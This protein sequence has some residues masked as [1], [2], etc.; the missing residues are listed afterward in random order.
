MASTPPSAPSQHAGDHDSPPRAAT[1]PHTWQ[2]PTGPVEDPYAWM[3]DR[4]DPETIAYIEA[5]NAYTAAWYAG[6]GELRDAIFGEIRSRIQETDESVPF[7]KGGWWYTSRTVEGSNYPLRCRGRDRAT[8]TSEVLLDENA[9]AAGHEYLELGAFDV[10]PSGDLLLYSVDTD[11][12]EEYELRIRDLRT[13]VDL[14]DTVDRIYYSTAW[15]AD[16]RHVFYCVPNDQMRPH[17]VWRHELGTD[18]TADV[19][20]VQEDDARF[21]LHVDL[22]RDERWISIVAASQITTEVWL[23]PADRPTEAPASVAGRVDGREYG[24][25]PWGDRFVVLTND[26]AEDFRIMTA[27]LDRPGDWTEFVGHVPGRRIDD[28]EAFEHHLLIHEWADGQ[29]AIRVVFRDGT[30]RR[31]D[32]GDEPSD[33]E[34]DANP[35]WTASTVR[36]TYQSLTMPLSV[37]EEDVVTGERTLL[38]RQPV[39]NVD[40]TQYESCR[41]WATAPDGTAIPVDLVWRRGTPR[42]GTAPL[43]LYGYGAYE[44]STPPWFSPARLSLLDRGWVWALAHP[45]G[46]GELGRRWYLDGKLLAKRNTFD[47][48]IACGEH[49][50]ARGWCAPDRLAIRGGSAGG[51][52]VGACLTMRPDLYATVLAEVPFVDVVNSMSD[53][54]LPLTVNE[55][56]EWGDPR[57]EPYASYMGSYSPY[58]NTGP[59]DYPAIYVTSGL[60]DPRVVF[61]EPTKWTARLRAVNTGNRPLLLKTEMGAGHGG[62]SGRYDAW[63]DEAQTLAFL[64]INT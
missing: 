27:P 31:I 63:K 19:L 5:E 21:N 52:L 44:A 49:V 54:D 17:Q 30:D 39:P 18:Q 50:I 6:H 29:P 40:L 38:K 16:E 25:E 51:L 13:G 11:G 48:F 46:G 34:L 61:H 36:F 10:S 41:E 24:V 37:Y 7:R 58:D 53:P 2:R 14:A 35:E 59:A 62:P 4:D 57:S 33:V 12:S 43:C 22:S 20:V 56:E 60:N 28:I 45:R 42:D 32:T 23:I 1:R 55:W 64:L 26:D 15:S 47:D 8:A 9:L 3:A